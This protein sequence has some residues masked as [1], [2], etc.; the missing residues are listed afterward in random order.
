MLLEADDGHIL[1]NSV[2]QVVNQLVYQ[3]VQLDSFRSI[4]GTRNDNGTAKNLQQSIKQSKICSLIS[5]NKQRSK[6]IDKLCVMMSFL[7]RTKR[8]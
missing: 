8:R 1:G 3:Y 7:W 6:M 2:V 5:D 4:Y